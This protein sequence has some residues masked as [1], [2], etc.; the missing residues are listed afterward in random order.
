M[1][2]TRVEGS[3]EK[4]FTLIELLV[5]IAI[6]AILAAMLLPALASAKEKAQ[7]MQCVN[8]NKQFALA[9]HMYTSDNKESLPYPNWNSP[10]YVGW[11]YNPVGSTVPDITR[12]PYVTNPS[13]AYEG[14]EL[15]P[16]LKNMGVYRCPLDRTNTVEWRLR[17]NKL[18]TYVMTGAVCWFGKIAPRSYKLTDFRPLDYMMWE[19]DAD[20]SG[21]NYNDGSSYPDSNEGLGHRHGKIGGI[22]TAFGG[23]SLWVKYKAWANL[24]L[25]NT[26]NE[27]WCS[28]GDAQTG[29]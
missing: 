13:G 22:V 14:G 21:N 20:A 3:H 12:A 28:P 7:R 18:S 11:L 8:N 19:P 26:R 24:S 4:G 2:K 6:I 16:Y 9:T 23:H 15:W 29:R 25:S 17:A 1:A 10:W 5:V 27:L